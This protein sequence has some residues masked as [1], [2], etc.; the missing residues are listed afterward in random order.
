MPDLCVLFIYNAEFTGKII[1][2]DTAFH[3]L[4]LLCL[5]PEC[6]AEAPGEIIRY[7][8]FISILGFENEVKGKKEM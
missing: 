8:Y 6:F 4:F 7:Y 1:H 5:L 2:M 3:V